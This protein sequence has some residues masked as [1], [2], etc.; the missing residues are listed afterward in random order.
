MANDQPLAIVPAGTLN[1]LARDLGIDS[2][3]DTIRP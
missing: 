2:V 1:H 3:E